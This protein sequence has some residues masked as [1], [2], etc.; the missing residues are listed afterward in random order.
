MDMDDV[1]LHAEPSPLAP[2]LEL[3]NKGSSEA[4][5]R[6]VLKGGLMVRAEDA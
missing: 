5:D 4:G 6:A 1:S 2:E 3:G